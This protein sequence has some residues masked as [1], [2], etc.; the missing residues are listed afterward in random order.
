MI[1]YP[2][3]QACDCSSDLTTTT[4]TQILDTVPTGTLS[5]LSSPLY[6]NTELNKYFSNKPTDDITTYSDVYSQSLSGNDTLIN[7]V[8][9]YKLPKS[10]LVTIPTTNQSVFT[11]STDLPLGERINLFNQRSNFFAGLNKIKVTFAKDA[12]IN[13]FHYDNTITVLSNTSYSSGDLLTFVNPQTTTDKNWLYTANT[14]NGIIKGISGSTYNGPD[15]TSINVTYA[16]S[17]YTDQ[18]LTYALPYGSTQDNYKF[19]QDR[20]YFQVV[21]ALTVSQAAIL[22]NSTTNQSFSNLLESPTSV[23]YYEKSGTVYTMTD[24]ISLKPSDYYSDFQNQ[25]ILVLQRGVDPYSPKYINEYSIGVLFG[26]NENDTNFIFTAETRVN[27]PI[28]RIL[29]NSLSVQSFN[30]Q[31]ELF[32]QSY[33]FHPGIDG[34]TNAGYSYTGYTSSGVGFY[35]LVDANNYNSSILNVSNTNVI[36]MTSNSFYDPLPNSVKYDNSEDVTSMGYMY[37][38]SIPTNVSLNQIQYTYYSKS[39]R[40]TL[41]QTPML[42]NSSLN[43]V[44][45]TDRLPTSDAL[46]GG[47]WD[48]N[49][50]VLQQNLNFS[51]YL[52]NT[53][54]PT[55]SSPTFSSGADQTIPDLGDLPN[56]DKVLA[57][58]NCEQMVGLHCYQGF[59]SNF[60][61]NTHCADTDAVE[62][63]CYLFLRN[64]IIDMLKDI[65]SFAEWGYR[66]RFFYGLC[67]G[68]LS[69]SFMNNWINGS[70]YAF[71]IQVDTY[72]DNKNKPYSKFCRDVIYF[73]TNTNNFYYRSSPYDATL[74]RFV[75]KDVTGITGSINKR[76]LLFPT[77][78]INLGMKD[79]FYNEIIF[80]A[81]TKSY[82]MDQ[83]DSTSY[84]DT[85]DLINLFVISRITD[86]GFL[87]EILKIGDNSLN[88]LFSRNNENFFIKNRRIDGDLAQLM[89]INS[90]IGL[91]KF[92]PEFYDITIDTTNPPV[93]VLGT[94]GDPTIAVWFSSTTQ[95]IQTKDFITPGRIDFRATS[96]SN[97]VPYQYSIKSQTVPFYQW[98]LDAGSS[99]I[100]GNQ[101]NNWATDYNDIVSKQYQS[102]DRTKLGIPN[103]FRSSNSS[104]NDLYARGYIFSV[105]ANGYYSSI[106]RTSSK[107]LVG[108]PFQFYF[109]VVKG[110]SALDKFKTKYSTSE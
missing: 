22:W 102:L 19:P 97:F 69:Q 95:D 77:T 13:K 89:S 98:Q 73:D 101:Y 40:T 110:D 39:L 71:P 52:I 34:N 67:R 78:I 106:G 38:Q 86:E 48:L 50:S 15:V 27:I 75:G 90:E 44:M 100:F 65:G 79:S 55:I 51:V 61:I 16:T 54:N 36:S 11:L 109:G 56:S 105:D 45:R 107:F 62:N 30:N 37:T 5:Y 59:G 41:Q 7:N 68:V 104:I 46:D 10:N 35:G 60:S 9:V 92:S 108:A 28:Q 24:Q 8:N 72:Y 81:S 96:S 17:Q 66:F 20:E 57:S 33:F 49:P 76:N 85:S 70:L 3:C 21:T 93:T 83:L 47:S 6:Y 31:T 23:K 4:N 42:I 43:N 74:Q 80:D 53:D 99:T 88:Q 91:I 14:A 1:T 94:A 63:G 64:P 12:N 58:F 32:Y 26:T 87:Q 84:G 18:T 103:Y 82:V 25:T 2:D 29:N